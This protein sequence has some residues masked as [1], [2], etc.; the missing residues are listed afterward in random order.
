MSRPPMLAAS[1]NMSACSW[2]AESQVGCRLIV[3]SSAK[4]RRPRC[5]GAV[6]GARV[7][8]RARKASMSERDD[9]GLGG[10]LLAGGLSGPFLVIEAF[11]RTESHI[12]D[13]HGIPKWAQLVG[14]R[15]Q[16]R[17]IGAMAAGVKPT[18]MGAFPG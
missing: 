10:L 2:Q 4:I 11:L 3:A 16:P 8:T 7:R 17:S 12:W 18:R 1:R 5:P 6:V 15:W 9:A 13:S 14:I